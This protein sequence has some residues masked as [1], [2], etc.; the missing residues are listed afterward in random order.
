MKKRKLLTDIF[1][2]VLMIAIVFVVLSYLGVFP[3]ADNTTVG[4]TN[5]IMLTYVAMPLAL[6][7]VAMIDIVFPIL[8]NKKIR[9]TVKFKV[10]AGI[11]IALFVAA[12][13][14]AVLFFL[15]N[16]FPQ[17]NEFVG[18]AIFCALYFAQFCINL[19]PKPS[20][21]ENEEEN[22]ESYDAADDD[23]E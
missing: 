16:A 3:G 19:D 14:F 6:I 9:G 15:A 11:K 20:Q 12:I 8:D 17:M 5:Y 21:V 18:V 7:S 13:V 10:K 1:T 22:Y 4:S 2:I 23:D